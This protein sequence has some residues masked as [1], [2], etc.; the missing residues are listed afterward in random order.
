[1]P[2]R[3]IDEDSNDWP[4]RHQQCRSP[5]HNPPGMISLPPGLYEHECPSCGA[6]QRFRVPEP[7]TLALDLTSPRYKSR[8]DAVGNVGGKVSLESLVAGDRSRT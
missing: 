6:K 7:P 1:M 5:E 4:S 8:L 2:L 3:R